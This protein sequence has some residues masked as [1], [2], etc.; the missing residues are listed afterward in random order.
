MSPPT[1]PSVLDHPHGAQQV[2][3]AR[4]ARAA[5]LSDRQR[6][7]GRRGAE[8][9]GDRRDLPAGAN[10]VLLAAELLVLCLEGSDLPFGSGD[11]L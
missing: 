6:V 5:T 7:P 9:P 1:P 11:V 8:L 10:S 2:I 4:C 3:Q